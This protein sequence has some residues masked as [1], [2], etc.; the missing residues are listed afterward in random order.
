MGPTQLPPPGSLRPD[1]CG[2]PPP[3]APDQLF[4]KSRQDLFKQRSGPSL[5]LGIPAVPARA[6]GL[7]RSAST[8]THPARPPRTSHGSH[9]RH[10][11][12]ASLHSVRGRGNQ[13]YLYWILIP[14]STLQFNVVPSL[15]FF[16]S[17][18]CLSPGRSSSSFGAQLRC[19]SSR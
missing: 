17:F 4:G 11:A 7:P 18:S 8:P 13:H 19:P 12:V 16:G 15:F 10:R 3:P 5:A 14:P 1:P 2:V 6:L 9:A